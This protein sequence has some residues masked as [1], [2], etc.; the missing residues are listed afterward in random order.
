MICLICGAEIPEG[1]E[2]CPS[3]EN[4]TRHPKREELI[5]WLMTGYRI[6]R[7]L[8][9]GLELLDVTQ[10]KAM[11]ATSYLKQAPGGNGR[12]SR[13]ETYGIAIVDGERTLDLM[14]DTL[15]RHDYLIS[16][17]AREIPDPEGSLLF[18]RYV[19]RYQ[20]QDIAAAL[21]YAERSV[22]YV[23]DKALAALGR[24]VTIGDMYGRNKNG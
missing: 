20:W 17:W 10:E 4:G 21:H 11:R 6:V 18:L 12:E 5:A 9:Q 23:H 14:T 24:K 16:K 8:K 7:E 3:C 13:I 15:R 22:F 1:V 2:V 19:A